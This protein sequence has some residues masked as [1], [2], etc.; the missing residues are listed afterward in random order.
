MEDTWHGLDSTPTKR[1]KYDEEEEE[2]GLK[3]LLRHVGECDIML[4][5]AF[6]VLQ[7][8]LEM[9]NHENIH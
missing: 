8:G 1:T 3:I 2:D 9:Q 7:V 4:E 6:Q 5:K